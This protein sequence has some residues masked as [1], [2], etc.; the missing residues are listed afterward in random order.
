MLGHRLSALMFS[1]TGFIS[2]GWASD[3]PL[4]SDVSAREDARPTS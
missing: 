4:H 2:F 3:V 1:R